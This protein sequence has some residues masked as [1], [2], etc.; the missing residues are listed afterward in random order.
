MKP[1]I[2]LSVALLAGCSTIVPTKIDNPYDF[3]QSLMEDCKDPEFI[4]PESK[5]SETIKVII[6]NNTRST[7][8]RLSKKALSE[9]IQKR[10]EVFEKNSK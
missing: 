8:C 2:L 9:M 10:K 5:L 4:N 6:E 1:L 7:E 3:P